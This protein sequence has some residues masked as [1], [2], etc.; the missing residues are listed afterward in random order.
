MRNKTNTRVFLLLLFIGSAS[1][2]GCRK[3]PFIGGVA[4]PNPKLYDPKPYDFSYLPKNVRSALKLNPN[5]PETVDGVALGRFLFYDPI[6]SVDSSISCSSCHKQEN[7]FADGAR[8]S[9]GVNNTLGMRNS[10]G[11]INLMWYPKFFWDGRANSLEHQALFPIQDHL[12]MK[13]SLP[14][15]LVKLARRKGYP[16][17]FYK[18]FGDS[19]ISST[20]VAYA[21]AQF[22]RTLISF[23]SPLDSSGGFLDAFIQSKYGFNSPEYKG[24]KVYMHDPTG[25]TTGE[26]DH[27]HSL[28]PPMLATNLLFSNNALDRTFADLG[29]GNVTHKPN[30]Y[31]QFKVPTLRNVELTAPY[32]HDGRFSTLEQVVDHY[33]DHMV[34]SNTVAPFLKQFAQQGGFQMSVDDKANLVAFLKLLTDKQFVTNPAFASP[35]KK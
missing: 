15:T 29:Y 19:S 32:M 30:E 22:A 11:L 35:F 16:T 1:W 8:L 5:N 13:D 33:S 9:K 2:V 7:A 10:M 27:C 25:G 31:G 12:E 26:C 17:L 28:Q 21:L 34:L 24:F 6:L 4:G 23:G 14:N 3:D 18:A 20:R